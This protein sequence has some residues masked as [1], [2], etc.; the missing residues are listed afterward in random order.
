MVNG[1]TGA[2]TAVIA[3]FLPAPSARRG[4][5]AIELLFPSVMC[6]GVLMLVVWLL[7]LDP[8]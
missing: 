4:C 6:A 3:T 5:A 2:F 7:R 1:T 8:S